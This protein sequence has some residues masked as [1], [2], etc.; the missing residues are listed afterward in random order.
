MITASSNIQALIVKEWHMNTV[1]LESIQIRYLSVWTRPVRFLQMLERPTG[2][3]MSLNG[4]VQQTGGT[5]PE[6]DGCGSQY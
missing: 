5:P 4:E 3:W 1:L 6:R 2:P